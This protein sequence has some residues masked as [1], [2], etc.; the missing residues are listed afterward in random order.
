MRQVL[1]GKKISRMVWCGL[2]SDYLIFGGGTKAD[3]QFYYFV[4]SMG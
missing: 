2:F 3:L 4:V 1:L